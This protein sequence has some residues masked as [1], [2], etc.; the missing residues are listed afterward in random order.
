MYKAKVIIAVATIVTV[1]IVANLL[2]NYDRTP[3]DVAKI[4]GN[5]KGG[6][7]ETPDD[8]EEVVNEYEEASDWFPKLNFSIIPNQ[9]D[10]HKL[11]IIVPYRDR[12]S[13]LESISSPLSIL[14]N[15]IP[16]PHDSKTKQH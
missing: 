7:I 6:F 11:A 2:Y 16:F 9:N 10:A 15:R 14:T 4:S 5:N 12:L 3:Y 1:G 8:K 13:H